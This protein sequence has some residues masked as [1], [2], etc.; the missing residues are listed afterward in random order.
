MPNKTFKLVN[1]F[2][3][4]TGIISNSNDYVIDTVWQRLSELK[5]NFYPRA[6]PSAKQL[7]IS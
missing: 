6:L 7:L 1:N 3:F 5:I 4:N 2:D